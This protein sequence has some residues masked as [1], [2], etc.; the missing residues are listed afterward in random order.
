MSDDAQL[1]HMLDAMLV[2][3]S[4]AGPSEKKKEVTYADFQAMLDSTPLFM[5]EAP[6]DG[7][8]GN[9]V[10]E[11]LRSL[12][13]EGEGDGES[14]QTGCQRVLVVLYAIC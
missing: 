8:E 12:V 9:E 4:T 1:D 2:R 7:G 3:P 6:K 10:L 11:A 13:F 14:A 5:S